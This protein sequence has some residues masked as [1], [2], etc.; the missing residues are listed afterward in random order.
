MRLGKER[1][2]T[3]SSLNNEFKSVSKVEINEARLTEPLPDTD[4]DPDPD[5]DP[6]NMPPNNPPTVILPEPD[7][8][9]EAPT[10]FKIFSISVMTVL[11]LLDI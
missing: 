4:P 7:P 11:A 5:P 1:T 8:E 2:L 10:A 6:P 3:S 9:A